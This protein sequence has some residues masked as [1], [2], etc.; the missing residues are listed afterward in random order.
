MKREYHH[1]Y[2]FERVEEE[3]NELNKS[4]YIGKDITMIIIIM[5]N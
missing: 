3:K 2:T 1:H 5:L 4:Y